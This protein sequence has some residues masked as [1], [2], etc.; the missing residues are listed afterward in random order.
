[1]DEPRILVTVGELY[2]PEKE[3]S[4]RTRVDHSK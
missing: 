4:D 3:D 1:L 2:I